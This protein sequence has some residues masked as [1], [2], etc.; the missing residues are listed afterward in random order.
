MKDW[1]I[2]D[3]GKLIFQLD[4]VRDLDPRVLETADWQPEMRKLDSL[5]ITGKGTVWLYCRAGWEAVRAGVRRITVKKPDETEPV[6]IWPRPAGAC[7]GSWFQTTEYEKWTH[8]Q[9]AV[10]GKRLDETILQDEPFGFAKNDRMLVLSGAAAVWMY[11]AA[12]VQA[13]LAGVTD[14]FYSDPRRPTLFCLDHKHPGMEI[15]RMSEAHRGLV[16]G[17]V[18][19]PNSG[20]SV[21]SGAVEEAFLLRE[22]SC[23]KF[24]CDAASPTPRWYLSLLPKDPE[25]A[26]ELRNSQK[27]EWTAE[28]EALVAESLRNLRKTLSITI[29]DLPGGNHKAVPPMRMPPGREVIM[30]EIDRFV[31][32]GRADSPEIVEAWRSELRKHGLEDRVAAEI[33]SSEP[34]AAPS[35]TW[36]L[37]TSVLRGRITGL[38][39]KNRDLSALWEP[40]SLLY[41]AILPDREE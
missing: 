34:N 20:K 39:R 24:D 30:R 14:L 16:L 32:L 29:A 26:K 5:E 22:Q 35:L 38:D 33:I 12:G 18:G 6:V 9:F 13:Y 25:N 19:D 36:E 23:W 28:L 4:T 10:Q 27:T 2:F 1:Y 17:I 7:S 40:L 11:A 3:D 31:I 37:N 15:P 21:L 8:F 41:S